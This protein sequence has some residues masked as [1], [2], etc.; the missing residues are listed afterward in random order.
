MDRPALLLERLNEIGASLDRTGKAHAL[1]GLG[2]VGI[3]LERL[4]EYSDLDFFAIVQEGHKQE[5]LENLNWLSNINPIDYA[6]RNTVDGYKVLYQDGVFCEFAVFEPQELTGIPFSEGRIVWQQ[7]DFDCQCCIP[8]PQRANQNNDLEW[9]I[10]EALTNLY[11][12]MCRYQRGEKLSGMRFVQSF[13]LDRL[14]ELAERIETPTPELA[15]QFMSD[16]RLE[17]R[18]PEFARLLPSFT[19][20]YERTPESTLAQLSFLNTHFSINQAMRARI[21]DLCEK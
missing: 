6:V 18:F 1:L 8:K 4:D 16:R 3:E 13:A 21:L 17:V 7:P 11:V 15:D 12:G 10:G 5:F 20:G 9:I 19:Q 14:I 2:S